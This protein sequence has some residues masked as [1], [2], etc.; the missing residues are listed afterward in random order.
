MSAE[1]TALIHVGALTLPD[2]GSKRINAAYTAFSWDEMQA[3]YRK[4]YPS[5]KFDD[6]SGAKSGSSYDN[7][8]GEAILK[9]FGRDGWQSFESALEDLVGRE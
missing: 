5:R 3:V 9:Q 6:F 8:R 7:K 4:L 2:V 1:D